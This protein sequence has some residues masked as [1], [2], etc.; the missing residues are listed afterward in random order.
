L[1]DRETIE[2]RLDAVER[3]VDQPMVRADIRDALKRM[4]DLERLVSR[5]A[6]GLANPR[7]LAALRSSLQ[8][9]PSLE[10]PLLR[11]G[12]GKL[13]EIRELLGDH[14]ETARALSRA[15][16]EDPPAT[17]REGGIIREGHDLELDKLRE[18]NK[19][20]KS[21]IAG[22]ETRERQRSGIS[23]LK[24][25]FNSVFG[26]YLE[27][28]KL[29][30]DKV[31]G[32]YVRKQTTANAERYITAELKDQEARV[33]GAEEKAISLETDLFG[34][35]RL[36]VAER[37]RPL[38][39]TARALAELDALSALAETAVRRG[40]VRPEL[41]EEDALL[42]EGGRHPVVEAANVGFVP[43]DTKLGDEVRLVVL[44]GPNMAGKSTF[45]R[46]IA[47]IQLMAQIGSFVPARSAKLGL[48]DRIFA[49][50][51]AKDELALGQ[52][53]FMVEMVESANILNHANPRSLVILD[54]V[55]RGTSTF[56]GMAIAQA[57]VEHLAGI[58]AKT[59]FATHY[60]QLNALA[61]ELTGVANF[62]VAVEEVADEVIWTH[63]VVPGGA[64]RSY[65]IHVARMAGV[66]SPVLRRATDI[67]RDLEKTEPPKPALTQKRLQLSLFEA[68]EP[69]VVGALRDLDVDR[70]TPMDALRTLDD[71]KRRYS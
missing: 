10:P 57:M 8:A 41:T 43:N 39:E 34:R 48:A 18:L 27:V 53:T 19:G 71:F 6:A 65:G 59:L 9:L 61:S 25:G 62:R 3:L 24:V 29:H 31:P 15:L 44:T 55:G 40:Y 20:G 63:R 23:T 30:S 14:G 50:I 35:L 7:D 47:L 69:E 52:S 2:G 58:G 45:L 13:Q 38:L 5:C 42:I 28:S 46:Q 32:D 17:L 11:V 60:H 21:Y 22:L 1:L 26:Y 54:E 70:L 51:G 36:M 66:P 56:D 37:A 16:V 68:E 49:R 33:L 12:V 4:S 64:D 67:L